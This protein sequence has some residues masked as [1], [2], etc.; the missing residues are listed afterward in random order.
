MCS[1][2]HRAVPIVSRSDFKE[3]ARFFVQM[4]ENGEYIPSDDE[5]DHIQAVL[6]LLNVFDKDHRFETIAN[7]RDKAKEVRTMSEWLTNLIN[8]SEATGYNRGIEQGIEQ[9]IEKGRISGNEEGK[10][11]TLWGLVID[12]LLD[13]DVAAD[14]AQLS[15]AEFQKQG[16]ALMGEPVTE[17]IS[18]LS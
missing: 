9:G 6:H 4:R 2:L 17:Y 14:R 7:G 13:M 16:T 11:R 5:L 3:V 18:H 12:Q 10:I 8:K 1:V 15:V